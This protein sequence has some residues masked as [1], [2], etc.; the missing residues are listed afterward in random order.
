MG[1]WFL[2]EK[3]QV[4]L[5]M[6]GLL[7]GCGSSPSSSDAREFQVVDPVPRDMRGERV[8]RELSGDPL[9]RDFNVVDPVPRDSRVDQRR[10]EM[11]VVD[12]VPPDAS[13]AWG[14]QPRPAAQSKGA[15]PL[16]RALRARIGVAARGDVLELTAR[17]EGQRL[18]YRWK[19]S[20]GTLDRSDGRT[21]RW[22]PPREKGRH[23]AQLTVRD[24]DRAVSI[25][26]Y[27]HEVR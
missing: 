16:D 8:Y 9:P 1:F 2:D 7:G 12:M 27:L 23:L 5:L 10:R 19:V 3:A 21:A 15:L 6:A 4:A 14:S 26:V 25:D 22:T 20:G 13:A 17:A 24:G 11:Q 18:T